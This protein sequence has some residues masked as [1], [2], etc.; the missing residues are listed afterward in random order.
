ME[1]QKNPSHKVIQNVLA[2]TQ[3]ALEDI[4]CSPPNEGSP[5]EI[6]TY[7]DKLKLM[8]KQYYSAAS[9]SM[10]FY[11][12]NKALS[13]LTN[14]RIERRALNKEVHELISLMNQKLEESNEEL[15]SNINSRSES[16]LSQVESLG[17]PEVVEEL[18]DMT[19]K[20]LRIHRGNHYRKTARSHQSR[21][22]CYPNC[23]RLFLNK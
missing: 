11:L 2:Q 10:D 1:R 19:S 7:I 17:N 3:S 5:T 16:R 4:M 13:E 6:K 23:F 14:Q 8:F 22:S 12:R 9:N 20:S 18:I 15:V 21:L